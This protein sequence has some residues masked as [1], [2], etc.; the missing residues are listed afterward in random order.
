VSFRDFLTGM[1]SILD[2]GG[3]APTPVHFRR[4]YRTD[5]EALNADRMSIE[6]DLSRVWEDMANAWRGYEEDDE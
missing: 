6:G 5:R 2:I 3:T 1:G 4:R